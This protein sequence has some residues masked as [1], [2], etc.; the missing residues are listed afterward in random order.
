LSK[1]I[2]WGTFVPPPSLSRDKKAKNCILWFVNSFNESK[3]ANENT[4]S[5][6]TISML[7]SCP[8]AMR[9]I[10]QSCVK[11]KTTCMQRGGISSRQFRARAYKFSLAA[12]KHLLANFPFRARRGQSCVCAPSS[13]LG[14]TNDFLR[15]A[16]LAGGKTTTLRRG[17]RA[18]SPQT[19]KRARKKEV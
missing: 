14:R 10:F 2:V 19:E 12:A 15:R 8:H 13:S 9:R 7:T 11:L 1:N 3:L 16:A 17:A 5:Y 18:R 4:Q 6:C